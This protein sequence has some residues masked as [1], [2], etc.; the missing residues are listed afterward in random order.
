MIQKWH[1]NS[2]LPLP[3]SV[4]SILDYGIIC[5][6]FWVIW[7]RVWGFFPLS[8][9]KESKY[10]SQNLQNDNLISACVLYIM[11]ILGDESVHN[12]HFDRLI[13]SLV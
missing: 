1:L 11:F 10:K 6:S 7:L 3:R 13:K 8:I 5:S 12:I 2:C 9:R 4:I